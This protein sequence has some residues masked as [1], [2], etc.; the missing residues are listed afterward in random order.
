MGKGKCSAAWVHYI[1]IALKLTYNRKK[2]FKTLHYWSR[3]MFNFDFLD[4][5]LRNVSPGHFVYDFPIEMFLLLYSINWPNF[6]ACLLLL[7]DILSNICIAIACYPGC[8]IMDFETNLIFLIERG[9]FTLPKS[10]DK[11]LNIFRT[12]R[13]FK[14]K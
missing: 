6:I 5:G 7:L 11:I 2:L 9:F 10:H 1:S 8:D 12:K 13:A 14:V 3:D 4:K